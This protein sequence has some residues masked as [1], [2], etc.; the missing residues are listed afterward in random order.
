MTPHQDL[1]RQFT[2]GLRQQRLDSPTFRDDHRRARFY[3]AA[4]ERS[5]QGLPGISGE[6]ARCAASMH[7]MMVEAAAC[8]PALSAVG[9]AWAF[10]CLNFNVRLSLFP[11]RL[12]V[13]GAP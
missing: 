3:A 4:V 9:M 6:V 5:A 13:R 11:R 7:R 1:V 12:S 2:D 10:A 8:G